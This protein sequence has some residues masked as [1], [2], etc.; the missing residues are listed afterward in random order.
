MCGDR[1]SSSGLVLD[2]PAACPMTTPQQSG[3]AAG[4]PSCAS[5]TF[6]WPVVSFRASEAYTSSLHKPC[7]QGDEAGNTL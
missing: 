3:P 4:S 1:A 5:Q 7:G 6:C 2:D